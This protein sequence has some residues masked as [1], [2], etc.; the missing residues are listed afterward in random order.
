MPQQGDEAISLLAYTGGPHADSSA[1]LKVTDA[2]EANGGI[3]HILHTI[4]LI[5]AGEI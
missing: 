3:L 4:L 1:F 5:I 2:Q